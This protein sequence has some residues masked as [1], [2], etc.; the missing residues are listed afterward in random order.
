MVEA[1]KIEV[2][3]TEASP[4]DL[5]VLFGN[6]P[7][8]EL[9]PVKPVQLK[10]ALIVETYSNK[11]L[12]K[13]SV[14]VIEDKR[15]ENLARAVIS[16]DL[17][18]V[19]EKNKKIIN[20]ERWL[21]EELKALD[22]NLTDFDTALEAFK[23]VSPN[24]TR[25]PNAVKQRWRIRINLAKKS[26]KIQKKPADP[27][28]TPT[29]KTSVK[30]PKL[31]VDTPKETPKSEKRL[32]NLN[33][34]WSDAEMLAIQDLPDWRDA[35]VVYEKEFGT[36]RSRFAVQ[37]QWKKISTGRVKKRRAPAASTR[38]A[39]VVTSGPSFKEIIKN[40]GNPPH[41]PRIPTETKVVVLSPPSAP[42]KTTIEFKVGDHVKQVKPY[43]G[44]T[45]SK[46]CVVTALVK[47][48]VEVN[49]GGNQYYKISPDCLEIT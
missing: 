10:P 44:R 7:V 36:K 28:D 29:T 23:K 27:V 21:R 16:D 11:S 24:S 42:K 31:V 37:Q 5:K 47:G 8:L 18:E 46:I 39:I 4:E 17:K 32:S 26:G 43:L 49:A 9:K 25:T 34:V 30:P 1:M 38:E 35:T 6:S 33:V 22:D 12:D 40:T 45:V 14:R 20:Y 13:P 41:E 19:K 48:L 3:I 15:E 2:H